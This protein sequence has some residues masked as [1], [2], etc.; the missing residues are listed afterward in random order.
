[1]GKIRIKKAMSHLYY[2]WAKMMGSE[3]NE[4][5]QIRLVLRSKDLADKYW[6]E[7][8][9]MWTMAKGPRDFNVGM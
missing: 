5:E 9:D 1:M 6:G 3:L 2:E 8:R 4:L 7:K